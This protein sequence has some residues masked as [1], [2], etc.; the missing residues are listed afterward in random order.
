MN[1]R[2]FVC[3]TIAT[4]HT[5]LYNCSR[6]RECIKQD[7][8]IGIGIPWSSH[9][10]LNSAL[11]VRPFRT[12]VGNV[13]NFL[14]RFIIR[15]TRTVGIFV[16]HFPIASLVGSRIDRMQEIILRIQFDEIG[17]FHKHV[18]CVEVHEYIVIVNRWAGTFK[19]DALVYQ[20]CFSKS[21]WGSL[22]TT[23]RHCRHR[24]CL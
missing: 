2:T 22:A 5:T 7:R 18:E 19:N 4:K 1:E 9:Q 6:N 11:R 10:D 23:Y 21:F 3:R 17:K 24:S 13:A 15:Y 20:R 16:G 12:V 8:I 14:M